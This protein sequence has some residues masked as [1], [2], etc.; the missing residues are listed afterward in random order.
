MVKKFPVTA[1]SAGLRCP[2]VGV[3]TGGDARRRYNTQFCTWVAHHS[4]WERKRRWIRWWGV[5]W[6]RGGHRGTLYF[7]LLVG[8]T[9]MVLWLVSGSIVTT[10]VPSERENTQVCPMVPYLYLN[11]TCWAEWTVYNSN[12]TY[13][14]HQDPSL[15]SAWTQPTNEQCGKY[16]FY[17]PFFKTVPH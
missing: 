11:A 2:E 15:N 8:I 7:R 5:E 9:L 13:F 16:T 4:S 3:L 10:T 14:Y 1:Y 6:N 17:P 12:I